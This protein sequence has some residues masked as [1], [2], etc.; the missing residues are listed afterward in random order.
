MDGAHGIDIVKAFEASSVDVEAVGPVL[1]KLSDI[2]YV[3]GLPV[4]SVA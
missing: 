1:Y 2:R 4:D 3:Y